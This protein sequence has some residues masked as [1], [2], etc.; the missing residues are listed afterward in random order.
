MCPTCASLGHGLPGGE[1]AARS[2]HH[3]PVEGAGLEGGEVV[4]GGGGGD[5]FV[6]DDDAVVDQQ[7]AVG[8]QV[9]RRP[10]PAGLQ[11]VCAALVTHEQA[12]HLRWNCTQFNNLFMSHSKQ[13]KDINDGGLDYIHTFVDRWLRS[14]QN[15]NTV[16][17]VLR[18][19]SCCI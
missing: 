14:V 18:G 15:K 17:A 4:G 19:R 16:S 1:A 11:A 12:L 2:G 5:A 7:E 10:L 6:L 3:H 9:P 13:Y 8:V